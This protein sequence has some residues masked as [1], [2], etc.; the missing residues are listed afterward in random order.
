MFGGGGACGDL[1][2]TRRGAPGMRKNTHALT[3]SPSA[4]AT[5]VRRSVL[6]CVKTLTSRDD[7]LFST[8]GEKITSE[9]SASDAS[10]VSR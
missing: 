1:G 8:Q 9:I 4:L 5:D 3:S 10:N 6:S 7:S 2:G